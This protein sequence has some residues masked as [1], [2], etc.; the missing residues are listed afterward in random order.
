MNDESTFVD[1]YLV[2]DAK[3][4][5]ILESP[6][7]EELSSDPR[8]PL[9]GP[10]GG[11]FSRVILG[12][13][14]EP[15]GQL[16]RQ[17]ESRYPYSLMNTF[18]NAMQLTDFLK[19]LN[20]L[21]DKVQSSTNPK[22]PRA[23]RDRMIEV[24]KQS[25]TGVTKQLDYRRRLTEA[26]NSTG[27]G[28]KRIVVCG[29]KAQA[30]FEWTFGLKFTSYASSKTVVILSQSAEIF[31]IAHPSPKS[32]NGQSAWEKPGDANHIEALKNFVT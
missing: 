9:M 6:H 23:L 5:F 12:N 4:I 17:N 7:T 26:L 24:Y 29:N 16:I 3:A 10:S 8:T 32:G 21:L 19:P 22:N 18:R 27:Q 2:S 11:V 25:D 1:D 30:Y 28:R 15:A 14:T 20:K 31:S 13:P